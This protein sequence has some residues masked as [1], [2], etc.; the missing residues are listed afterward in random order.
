MLPFF[1]IFGWILIYTFGIAMTLC[2]FLFLWM[3]KKLSKRFWYNY[4]FFIKNIFWFFI[5]VFIFSRLFFVLYK[6]EDLKHLDSP[7]QF[8]IAYDYNFSLFWALFWFFLVLYFNLKERKEKLIDYIDWLV[9]SFLFIAPLWFV[10]SFLWGQVYWRDTHF[11]LEILYTHPHSP[12]PFTVEVFPLP[13]VYAILSFLLFCWSYIA[14]TFI[15]NVKWV[16]WYVS[17]IVFFSFILIF[18]FFSWK[19]DVLWIFINLNQLFS[20]IIIWVCA[21]NLKLI[22]KEK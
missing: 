18:D 10:W 14:S 7:F 21:Y 11:W 13:V 22:L 1:E 16:I 9:L 3:L 15:S 19:T 2:F 4:K 20:L 5:S 8:F 6:W 12:V 17:L